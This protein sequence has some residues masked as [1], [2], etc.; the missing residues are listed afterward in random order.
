VG[1][2]ASVARGSAKDR[3]VNAHVLKNFF[4]L[5]PVE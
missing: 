5:S 2:C 3:S 4:I 1:S